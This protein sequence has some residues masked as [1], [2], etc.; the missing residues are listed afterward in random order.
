MT[1]LTDGLVIAG[2]RLAYR[3]RGRGEPVLFIH[4]TLSPS[5]GW[6]DV[7]PHFEASGLRVIAYDLLGDGRSERPADRD[8]SGAAQTELLEH[9]L[10][11]LGLEQVNIVAH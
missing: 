9:L 11:T 10:D 7:V 6:R 8:T 5:Y 3:D 1:V 4:G 2:V